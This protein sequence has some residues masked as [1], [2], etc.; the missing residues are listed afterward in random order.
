M[1]KSDIY[2]DS[3]TAKNLSQA[4]IDLTNQIEKESGY[5]PKK[6]NFMEVCGTHTVAF[7]RY[8]LRKLI[9]ANINI[10]AGPGCPVCVTPT[11]FIDKAI[12]ISKERNVVIATFG[13]MV[14]VPG[15]DS[16][17][18]KERA[19]GAR[20]K[21]VYSVLDALL[22]AKDNPDKLVVFLGI[23]FETTAPTG[24]SALLEAKTEKI[25]NFFI[26]PAYKLIP[27]AMEA[28]LQTK[29][30]ALD[31]F[32]CPGHVSAIIGSKPYEL[33]ARKYRIPC[34]IAGFEPVDILQAIYMLLKQKIEGVSKVEI[35]YKRCVKEDGNIKAQGLLR[36]VFYTTDTQW[37]GLGTI[38]KSGLEI[39]DEFKDFD[40]S[41]VFKIDVPKERVYP[42]CRC[43]D[44]LRGVKLPTDCKLF[45]KVC[46]PENPV[47][48]CMVSSE[49]TC[50]AYYK[51]AS[52]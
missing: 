34:V 24:A 7:F 15:S 2:R 3:K 32:I 36:D 25:K 48:P 41:K 19:N 26:L 44:I 45:G 23:G 13:D 22:F 18:E 5:S 14:K 12:A 50:S 1:I 39:N 38:E 35:A 21:V 37:R 10:I 46:T 31:G 6:I 51:Y 27:P 47:G 43:G 29:E 33:I 9:P 28:I 40:A 52:N 17:L 16:S 11:G 49:G 4:I 20:I 30:I 42:G 8:G